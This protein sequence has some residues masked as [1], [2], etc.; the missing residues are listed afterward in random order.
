MLSSKS[1]WDGLPLSVSIYFCAF[2]Q[3]AKCDAKARPSLKYFVC[4][5]SGIAHTEGGC[6]HA[7]QFPCPVRLS[8]SRALPFAQRD[9]FSWPCRTAY[10]SMDEIMLW[11]VSSCMCCIVVASL[12]PAKSAGQYHTAQWVLNVNKS[13]RKLVKEKQARKRKKYWFFKENWQIQ[14]G[15]NAPPCD[16]RLKVD[17]SSQQRTFGKTHTQ[18]M[19]MR[20]IPKLHNILHSYCYIHITF[21]RKNL[22]HAGFNCHHKPSGKGPSPPLLLLRPQPP[23]PHPPQSPRWSSG[24]DELSSMDLVAWEAEKLVWSWWTFSSTETPFGFLITTRWRT[25]CCPPTDIL[26]LFHCPGVQCIKG[27]IMHTY[28][29]R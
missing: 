25:F 26:F 21:F 19:C 27:M 23:R 16:S 11:M 2:H 18:N 6:N 10:I 4:R 28:I 5:L 29:W 14:W 20:N 22:K 24:R 17:P 13:Y 15:G 1:L 12:F 9:L 8:A 7:V 3:S